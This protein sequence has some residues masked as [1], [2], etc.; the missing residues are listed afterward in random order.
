MDSCSQEG[1]NPN[2]LK[3]PPDGGSLL[4]KI[5]RYLGVMLLVISSSSLLQAQTVTTGSGSGIFF[6]TGGGSGLI[7]LVGGEF[8]LPGMGLL[9]DDATDGKLEAKFCPT[10]ASTQLVKIAFTDFDLAPG[11]TLAIFQGC[12]VDGAVEQAPFYGGGASASTALSSSWFIADCA[13]LDGCLTVVYAPN[14]DNNKG[15]GF[16]IVPS[17]EPR[18]SM[19]T[20]PSDAIEAASCNLNGSGIIGGLHTVQNLVGTCNVNK[21]N[22]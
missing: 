14:G 12:G 21:V 4:L 19:I 9:N 1:R 13:T 6:T 3:S 18:M 8:I 2:V 5:L 20:C 11:D 16:T 15:T 22:T 7:T 10:D 17:N